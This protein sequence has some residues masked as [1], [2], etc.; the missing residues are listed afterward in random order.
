MKR[1]HGELKPLPLKKP[2]DILGKFSKKKVFNNS[3]KSLLQP[4]A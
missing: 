1:E 2:K 3:V 4:T